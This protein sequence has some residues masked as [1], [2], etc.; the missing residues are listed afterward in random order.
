MNK[1]F[2]GV[3]L[4][5]KREWKAWP[6]G[7]NWIFQKKLDGIRMKAPKRSNE[8]RLV[9]RSGEDYT[10]ML[11][12]GDKS[13]AELRLNSGSK[14]LQRLAA[15]QPAKARFSVKYV[16][17]MVRGCP[18]ANKLTVRVG[19][20]LPIQIEYPISS[21]RLQFLLAPRIEAE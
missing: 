1:M 8:V 18:A 11:T 13:S 4:C 12:S 2:K 14:A 7:G 20:N 19:T 21:G 5:E 17:D 15:P 3:M 16:N 6:A 10:W 9:G